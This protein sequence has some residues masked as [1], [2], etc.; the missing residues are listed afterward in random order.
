MNPS[1]ILFRTHLWGLIQGACTPKDLTAAEELAKT[2]PQLPGS[3]RAW[4]EAGR[5]AH[6]L[7]ARGLAIGLVD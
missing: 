7:R 4:I 2:I 5:M 3:D 6:H 1:G